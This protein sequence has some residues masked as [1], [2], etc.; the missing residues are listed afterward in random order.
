M[1]HKIEIIVKFTVKSLGGEILNLADTPTRIILT[2]IDLINEGGTESITT[3]AIAERAGVNSAAVNYHFGS[4]EK[5][6]GRVLRMTMSHLFE[7]FDMILSEI[8]LNPGERFYFLLDYMIEGISRYPGLTRSYMFD[9]SMSGIIRKEFLEKLEMVLLRL[10]REFPL[11]HSGMKLNMGQAVLSSL[12]TVMLPEF[13]TVLTGEDLSSP[14]ARQAFLLPLVNRIPGI[15]IEM[16][17]SL[18]VRIEAIRSRAF[19]PE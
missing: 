1:K 14:K 13:F 19:K 16:T 12:S 18:A 3:R 10:A 15:Q 6:I 4:R 5:L 9:E 11:E 2:A 7:D 17:S 8:S